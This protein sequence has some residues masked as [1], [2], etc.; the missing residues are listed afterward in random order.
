MQSSLELERAFAAFQCNKILKFMGMDYKDLYEATEKSAL[1]RRTMYKEKTNVLSYYVVRM[2][3]MTNMQATLNWCDVNNGSDML[4]QFKKTAQNQRA[5][6]DFIGKYYNNTY[7]LNSVSCMQRVWRE[8][9][10]K[11]GTIAL[12]NAATN[13][14]LT[15]SNKKNFLMN[16]MRMSICELG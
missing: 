10:A 7:T 3:L 6:C 2:I 13:N 9:M 12:N 1:L 5:F 14:V 8:L 15:N 4:L 16:N 11:H